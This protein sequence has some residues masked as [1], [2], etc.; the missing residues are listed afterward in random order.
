MQRD[1]FPLPIRT[2]SWRSPESFPVSRFYS[3]DL[4]HR[5][6]AKTRRG[7]KRR[8][9]SPSNFGASF[10]CNEFCWC[11]LRLSSFGCCSP[12][13]I[14]QW[15]PKS[16]AGSSSSLYLLDAIC[17][18]G[19]SLWASDM[20]FKG[21]IACHLPTSRNPTLPNYIQH[22]WFLGIWHGVVMAVANDANLLVL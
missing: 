9:C 18:R 11:P 8:R 5:L 6:L 7:N 20:A 4:I 15:G 1:L 22:N 10:N 13:D 19:S 2:S 17:I 14:N 21:H 16:P 12:G 3:I